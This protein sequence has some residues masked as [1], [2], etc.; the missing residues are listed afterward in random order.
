MNHFRAY[1]VESGCLC[2]Q[3]DQFVPKTRYDMNV[4]QCD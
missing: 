2:T 4:D 3:Y 1:I